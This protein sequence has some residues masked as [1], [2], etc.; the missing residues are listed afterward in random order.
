MIS[1]SIRHKESRIKSF[2]ARLRRISRK[3]ERYFLAPVCLVP[4][5]RAHLGHIAGPLL[6][7]DVLKRHLRWSGAEVTMIATSDSHESHVAIRGHL[8]GRTS[9]EV[10]RDYHQQIGG[11]LAAM[12]LDYDDFIDPL[13]PE[14]IGQ[15]VEI[16]HTILDQV[17]MAG[18][19]R[20]S[21]DRMPR[22]MTISPESSAPTTGPQIGDIVSS[23]WHRG[24][25]PDCGGS[26]TGY[27]CE[28]CGGL[29]P[30]DQILDIR[31]AHFDGEIAFDD[32]QVMH[33][34]LVDGSAR[35]RAAA[36]A[37][38]LRGDFLVLLDRYLERNGTDVRLTVPSRWGIPRTDEGLS[39]DQVIWHGA[40][41]QIA[42][43][44]L[45]AQRYSE[46]TGYSYP[47]ANGSEVITVV[48]FG[49]DNAL[50]YL[51]GGLGAILGQNEFKPI[52]YYLVNY[53]YQLAGAKFSTS[54]RHVIWARDLMEIG[55]SDPDLAR[56]YLCYR[57]PEFEPANFDPEE[58]V[59]FHNETALDINNSVATA[60]GAIGNSR[61]LPSHW[62]QAFLTGYL[63][64]LSSA[65]DLGGH[66]VSA[67]HRVF[68]EWLDHG[69]LLRATPPDRLYSLSDSVIWR[70]R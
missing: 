25:C 9:V 50:P 32:V 24:R 2:P 40:T 61:V 15:Y 54:R 48:G 47:L 53:F 49:I 31:T 7:M 68:N 33:L 26:M 43:H 62:E 10:A 19:T 13:S 37:A 64:R 18:S 4:N 29:H 23:G 8:E 1:D 27:S 42:C 59:S 55:G 3:G 5:G 44:Y 35:V 60:L 14:W 52:D 34:N 56:L 69:E 28:A 20:I 66:S 30:A 70:C 45:A 21:T 38:G 67:A 57:N 6:R 36:E 39:E 51:V 22:L 16:N 11:D 12:L 46:M 41:L 63:E 58:F 17:V 65:L